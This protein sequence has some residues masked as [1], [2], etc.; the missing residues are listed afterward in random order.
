M[1]GLVEKGLMIKDKKS[2][3]IF[4]ITKLGA[5]VLGIVLPLEL[6]QEDIQEDRLFS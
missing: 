1:W 3:T 5:S 6:V 2:N 4:H